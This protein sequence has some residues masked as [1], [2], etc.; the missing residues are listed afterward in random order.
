[1]RR[2]QPQFGTTMAD[3]E[4]GP[5]ADD[6]RRHCKSDMEWPCCREKGGPGACVGNCASIAAIQFSKQRK[7][8]KAQGDV[9]SRARWPGSGHFGRGSSAPLQ[10][11]DM[12]CAYRG[13][14][15]GTGGGLFH[16][17][18]TSNAHPRDQGSE[19]VQCKEVEHA[20]TRCTVDDGWLLAGLALW[21][22][23]GAEASWTHA[24]SLCRALGGRWLGIRVIVPALSLFSPV[25]TCNLYSVCATD[26]ATRTLCAISPDVQ[27]PGPGSVSRSNFSVLARAAGP[28]LSF[29]YLFVF[30][31]RRSFP[32]GLRSSLSSLSALLHLLHPLSFS[33]PHLAPCLASTLNRQ[34]RVTP[35]HVVSQGP[36]LASTL[37][38]STASLSLPVGLVQQRPLNP[39]Q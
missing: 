10:P 30:I 18:G 2:R 21:D 28:T 26:E 13:I 39:A 17:Q 11:P 12:D 29:F 32:S 36:N 19:V 7:A 38:H 16:A 4:P 34:P 23:D 31:S 35:A 6:A 37:F 15:A 1:M 27:P 9:V 8:E 24:S 14:R 5:P 3:L 20:Q 25:V 33:A 22:A